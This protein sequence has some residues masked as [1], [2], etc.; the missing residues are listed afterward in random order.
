MIRRCDACFA[1][2]RPAMPRAIRRAFEAAANL[3]R[4]NVSAE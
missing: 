3:I 4:G 1:A 2:R